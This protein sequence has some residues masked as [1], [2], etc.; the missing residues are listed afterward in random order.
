[1]INQC[2]CIAGYYDSDGDS[3]DATVD[4]VS[5]P[6]GHFG[7][8]TSEV[9][10]G[11]CTAC[12]VGR[13]KEGLVP[14]TSADD[15]AT[16]ARGTY[17]GAIG[18]TA[19]SQCRTCPA[20]LP[21][22]AM[23]TWPTA[24]ATGCVDDTSFSMRAPGDWST[25][26]GCDVWVQAPDAARTRN[27]ETTSENGHTLEEQLR[28]VAA[29]PRAC[30]I[31][32]GWCA[33]DGSFLDEA[34]QSCAYWQG[35]GLSCDSSGLTTAGEAALH[36]A[37]PLSCGQCADT[38]AVMAAQTEPLFLPYDHAGTGEASAA[39]QTRAS[40]TEPYLGA[41]G[42]DNLYDSCTGDSVCLQ[43]LR[44]T[45]GYALEPWVSGGECGDP[46]A[47]SQISVSGAGDTQLNGV[48][49]RNTK[50]NDGMRWKK[51]D[52]TCLIDRETPGSWTWELRCVSGC[53]MY[54]P[55]CE[56]EPEPET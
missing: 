14:I 52:D 12:P 31:C 46:Q 21:R 34:G 30:G 35:G 29:C 45:P 26:E 3:E 8:R 11:N 50:T 33:D 49:Y 47:V 54:L 40:E 32:D 22:D 42:L 18:L 24:A 53:V 41:A 55:C 13:Y 10:M 48:Y 36:A 20:S 44:D 27:C 9:D 37:C 7:S 5:C 25:M 19:R 39:V 43:A 56:P 2:T 23:V 28:L 51:A 4:C 15:C 16:C 38:I 1:M 6:P 17:A